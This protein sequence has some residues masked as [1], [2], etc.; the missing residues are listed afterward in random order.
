MR[1][2]TNWASAGLALLTLAGLSSA[3]TQAPGKSV[4]KVSTSTP[5][6][7]V[8]KMQFDGERFVATADDYTILERPSNGT[9]SVGD[10]NVALPGQLK[11]KVLCIDASTS[12]GFFSAGTTGA[13]WMDWAQKE[14][15]S[16]GVISQIGIA[17]ATSARWCHRDT[18]QL[19]LERGA[20]VSVVD[21]RYS[22]NAL[23]VGGYQVRSCEP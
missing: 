10:V 3:Q 5:G 11:A 16:T 8:A 6:R 22:R 21:H 23:Q 1:S 18:L 7:V 17:Y 13:E 14:C 12:N 15:L 2:F 4:K 9:P 20:D 19:L